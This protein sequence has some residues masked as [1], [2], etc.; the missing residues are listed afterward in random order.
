M[1]EGGPFFPSPTGRLYWSVVGMPMNDLQVGCPGQPIGP[2][3]RA[4]DSTCSQTQGQ[5]VLV[6]LNSTAERHPKYGIVV[7]KD[8]RVLRTHYPALSQRNIGFLWHWGEPRSSCDHST[9]PRLGPSKGWW[10]LT[11]LNFC[12]RS[13]QVPHPCL[14]WAFS[15]VLY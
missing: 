14:G 10:H 12:Y 9:D 8:F 15:T 5:P 4:G 2:P 13:N 11:S 6:L 3:L 1:G 7:W